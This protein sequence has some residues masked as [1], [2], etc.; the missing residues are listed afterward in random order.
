MRLRKGG[1][2]QF[3]RVVLVLVCDQTIIPRNVG[4]HVGLAKVA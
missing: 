3:G 2:C 4:V 1:I